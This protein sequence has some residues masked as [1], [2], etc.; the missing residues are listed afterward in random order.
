VIVAVLLM[1]SAV[2]GSDV[3]DVS[4]DSFTS[5]AKVKVVQSVAVEMMSP[6]S[7]VKAKIVAHLPS[8]SAAAAASDEEEAE[9]SILGN[10]FETSNFEAD[11]VSAEDSLLTSAG[12]EAEAEDAPRFSSQPIRKL[13]AMLDERAAPAPQPSMNAVPPG[14]ASDANVDPAKL[15]E[16][17]PTPAKPA[18][19]AAPAP[20]VDAATERASHLYIGYEDP[21]HLPVGGLKIPV[22]YSGTIGTEA[23]TDFDYARALREQ[24]DPSTIKRAKCANGC[25]RKLPVMVGFRGLKEWP[26]R[27]SRSVRVP[28]DHERDRRIHT[29]LKTSRR[30]SWQQA[31]LNKA[32]KNLRES[33][34]TID[35]LRK[36]RKV[37]ENTALRIPVSA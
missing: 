23:G 5:A 21:N 27:S 26:A 1:A 35:K 20:L 11:E 37:Y 2:L 4:E 9:P 36:K 12:V 18:A 10:A 13:K 14:A 15:A 22:D 24:K 3:E 17:D 32:R 30:T 31:H 33:S 19:A 34:R 16:F 7:V 6:K 8:S 29:D 25:T 28:G